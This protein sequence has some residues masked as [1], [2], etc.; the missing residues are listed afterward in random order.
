MAPQAPTTPVTGKR[1]FSKA[2][3]HNPKTAA[4]AKTGRRDDPERIVCEPFIP[5]YP[6]D[7]EHGEEGQPTKGMYVK[8]LTA[9]ADRAWIKDELTESLLFDGAP[10]Y[11]PANK[12]ENMK[13]YFLVPVISPEHVCAIRWSLV[14]W[15]AHVL[16]L[17]S[18][19]DQEDRR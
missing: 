8:V 14:P 18:C 10:K 7:C 6:K 19:A 2:N 15:Y 16:R 11:F 4:A 17:L 13:P 1:S 3:F 12:I 9:Y 5:T